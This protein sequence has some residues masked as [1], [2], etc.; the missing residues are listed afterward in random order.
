[1]ID[2]F[3]VFCFD[4]DGTIGDT[5]PDIRNAWLKA[6]DKLNWT[7]DNFDEVFRVGNGSYRK[8]TFSR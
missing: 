6:L 2:R 3:E 4:F 5:E 1:M 8:G 7:A